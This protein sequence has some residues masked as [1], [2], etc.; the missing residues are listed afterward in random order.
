MEPVIEPTYQVAPV[1]DSWEELISQGIEAREQKDVAQRVLGELADKV[2]VAYGYDSMGKFAYEV[3]V[4][5][6]T[7]A[8][9]RD[10]FRGYKDKTWHDRLSYTHHLIAL[11]ASDP[12]AMLQ[13]AEDESW[14]AE[15]LALEVQGEKGETPPVKKPTPPEYCPKCSAWKVDHICG[16]RIFQ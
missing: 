5:K 11:G 10:V 6:R 4:N 8:R 1:E 15:H 9:Y 12:E 16:C 3:G 7:L 14:S 13:R 2:E